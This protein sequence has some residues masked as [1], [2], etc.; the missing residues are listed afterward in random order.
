MQNEWDKRNC[1]LKCLE[2]FGLSLNFH[3]MNAHVI[4]LLLFCCCC[5]FF[6]PFLFIHSFVV[7]LLL[8]L[9]L[10]VRSFIII[11]LKILT[12]IR[13]MLWLCARTFVNYFQSAELFLFE[14]VKCDFH[15]TV[16][17]FD[18]CVYRMMRYSLLIVCEKLK[19]KQIN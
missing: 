2:W 18:V 14:C 9:S 16:T 11:M 12:F 8:F 7:I 3:I 10:L 5:F 1:K 6:L 19:P 17:G 4:V 13:I 15:S